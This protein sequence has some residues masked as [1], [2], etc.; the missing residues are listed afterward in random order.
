MDQDFEEFQHSGTWVGY[1]AL[2]ALLALFGLFLVIAGQGG[3][4]WALLVWGWAAFIARNAAS[5][6]ASRGELLFVVRCR[7][8]EV[9]WEAGGKAVVVDLAKTHE[10]GLWLASDSG[11]SVEFVT[12]DGSVRLQLVPFYQCEA[13]FGYLGEHF[14][15]RLRRDGK[16]VR[17]GLTNS[18]GENATT[19]PK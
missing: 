16:L 10:V 6:Y 8:S 2:S 19:P 18:R 11:Q 15:G 5:A 7:G 13:L 1:A 17:E 12:T 4:L 3:W 9:S 14:T